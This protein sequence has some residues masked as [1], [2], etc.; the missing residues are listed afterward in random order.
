MVNSWTVI[1]RNRETVSMK[2]ITVSIDDDT[3]RLSHIKAAESGTSVSALVRAYLVGLVQDHAPETEFDRLRRLQDE[4]LEAIRARGG[5]VR[6]ADNLPRR[7][8]HERDALR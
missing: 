4:T 7:A 2:N 3:Y 8:L 6:A 1:H 5:G